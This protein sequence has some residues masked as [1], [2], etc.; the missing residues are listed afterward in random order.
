MSDTLQV[1]RADKLMA[2]EGVERMLSEGYS[3]H[4][5]TVGADGW[6][7]VIPLLYIWKDGEIRVH[8]TG[9]AGHFRANID[10]EARVCFEIDEPGEVFPYGRFECDTSVAYRSVVAFGTVRV[11]DDAVEKAAFFDDLMSKYHARRDDRPAS[12]F[13][14]LDGVT[15]YAIEIDR[16]T[17]KVSP[18]PDRED[19]WP[20]TD[21]TKTPN[22]RPEK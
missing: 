18:L 15:V 13:P 10:H 6:P 17:G 19:Q 22:A 14:R 21:S 20:M 7:Y 5:A 3:G 8:T 12:F 16:M 11:I 1:R 4:L 2:D 9:A